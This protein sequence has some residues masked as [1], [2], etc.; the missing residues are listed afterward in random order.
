[1]DLIVLGTDDSACK[2]T[3]HI[4][5]FYLHFKV[6]I[7]ILTSISSFLNVANFYAIPCAKALPSVQNHLSSAPQCLLHLND[8]LLVYT[9]G[10]RQDVSSTINPD[11]FVWNNVMVC[12]PL[13]SILWCRD[14]EQNSNTDRSLV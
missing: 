9:E 13:A 7:A 12:M 10:H 6:D 11:T 4:I 14:L 8:R 5:P 2:C 3:H 1:M